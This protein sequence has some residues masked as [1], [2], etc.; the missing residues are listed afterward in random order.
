MAQTHHSACAP[1]KMDGC[2]VYSPHDP[3]IKGQANVLFHLKMI[4]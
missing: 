2:D 3:V 4:Q 1:F